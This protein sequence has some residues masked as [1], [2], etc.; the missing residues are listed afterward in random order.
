MNRLAILALAIP[1]ALAAQGTAPKAKP[2]DYMA[3]AT[4]G[5]LA[6]AADYLA[7]S[8][9]G[10]RDS[11]FIRDYIVVEVAVY[12]KNRM[13]LPAGKF[14]LR[15][16]GKKTALM[17]QAP[18]MV[19]ASLQ[20]P[21]W[22]QH[23]SAVGYGGVGNG[24]VVIGQPAPVPRFPGDPNGQTR[25]MPRAPDA[26]EV[27]GVEKEPAASPE[28]IV[29]RGALP[30]G[31]IKPPVAGYLFFSFHGKLKSLKSVELVFDGKAG[32]LT[33]RLI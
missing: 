5:S 30:E 17:A 9:P 21:D 32:S 8:L 33:L 10:A 14:T 19:A 23:P 6:I 7:H 31:D 11:L 2:E 27:S 25:P 13:A 29:T 24:G 1:A 18:Q 12:A 3:H 15:L 16:N 20:Y 22:E 26:G 28:D 4:A